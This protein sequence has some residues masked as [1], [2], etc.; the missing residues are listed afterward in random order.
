VFPNGN[1][2]RRIM[3]I[4]YVER[5]FGQI[6]MKLGA[7]KYTENSDSYMAIS[8]VWG[9]T[10][11]INS[12]QF[13]GRNVSSKAK[14]KAL[15][16]ILQYSELPIWVDLISIDTDHSIKAKQVAAMDLVY[17]G[18]EVVLV[19]LDPEDLI[20]VIKAMEVCKRWYKAALGEGSRE[21]IREMIKHTEELI[22]ELESTSNGWL[23]RIWTMQEGALAKNVVLYTYTE[24]GDCVQVD[25]FWLNREH[26]HVSFNVLLTLIIRR[27]I[28]RPQEQQMTLND[29][30]KLKDLENVVCG[31]SMLIRKL[32]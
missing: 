26:S 7:T 5:N 14:A 19:L 6:K 20:R 2:D 17:A 8:H 12:G 3:E 24:Y 4:T 30:Q 29:C 25:T 32:F 10:D 1:V 28:S 18:A 16:Q 21:E 15:S 9:D 23:N 11:G 27:N 22:K 31:L 13:A